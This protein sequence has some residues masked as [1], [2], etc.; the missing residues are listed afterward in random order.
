MSFLV[1]T[2][3]CAEVPHPRTSESTFLASYVSFQS[4]RIVMVFA[5]SLL[6]CSITAFVNWSILPL[7]VRS[8]F[9]VVTHSFAVPRC[10]YQQVITRS[11]MIEFYDISGCYILR[12]WSFSIW[13]S[14]QVR[15]GVQGPGFDSRFLHAFL[16]DPG[17]LPN[18]LVWVAR[19]SL[20]NSS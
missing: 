8:K 16:C 19:C 17:E 12:P 20:F 10:R 11:E 9:V 13:E 1:V 3:N 15:L 6:L 5:V 14:I 4:K 2:Q 7:L 18:L